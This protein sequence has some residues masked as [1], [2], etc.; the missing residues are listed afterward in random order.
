MKAVVRHSYGSPDVLKLEEVEK[1][2]VTD[3][4]VLVRVY[5]SSVNPAEFYSMY[6]LY[7][8][9]PQ[10]G[11]TQ[12]K[13]P[14]IGTDFAGVVEAVGSK[15]IHLKVG[16]EV[17]GGRTGAFAEYVSVVNAVVRKPANI[18][19]EEAAAIP[20]AAVTALQGLRDYG[21]IKPGDQVLINGAAGGVGT[22]AVQ[23]A[24][25]LG[26]EV[27]GVTS[28]KNV[29]MIRSIGADHVIDYTKDDFT[30]NGKQY[31]ILLDIAGSRTWKEYKRVLKPK[32]NFV[33][34]GGQKG[35]KWIGPLAN[36]LRLKIAAMGSSQQVAF[37]IANFTREDLNLLREMVEA[38]KIKPV[39]EKVY[40]LGQAVDAMKYLATGHARGKIVLKIR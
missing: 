34:V 25:A 38:G 19:F 32:A 22:F 30:K 13:D 5:A 40:P 29:E 18:S 1:P 9:R 14:R 7:I 16:D 36:T 17:Y 26:A 39:V 23:I 28:T 11:W 37:F 27:T 12:P 33:I 4:G 21:K 35:N 2:T 6:G 31:D 10:S 3:D 24:K 20:T 15:V 8:M